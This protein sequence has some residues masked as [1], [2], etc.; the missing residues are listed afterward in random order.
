MSKVTIAL[1]SFVVGACTAF[2]FSMGTH[3]SILAQ[4]PAPQPRIEGSGIPAIVNPEAI[5][6]V[7]P[8]LA[9]ISN[10]EIV[11]SEQQLDG[12]DCDRCTFNTPVLRY[13]GGVFRFTNVRFLG[14]VRVEFGGAAANALAMLA[15]V[16][17]LSL[18]RP[19]IPPQPKQPITRVAKT[20]KPVTV[21]LNSPF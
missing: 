21:T 3:T 19:P 18:S 17:S 11:G 2:I 8:S 15:V 4:A 5:P 6:V 10:V 9:R 16:Q 13:N 12:L 14:T 7:R 20:T 1:G